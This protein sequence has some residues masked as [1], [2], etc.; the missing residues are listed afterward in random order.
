MYEFLQSELN[1]KKDLKDAKE[2]L[3]YLSEKED[4]NLIYK[5]K[6]ESNINLKY[7]YRI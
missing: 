4:Y 3:N 1:K 5:M 6:L 2:K 7:F